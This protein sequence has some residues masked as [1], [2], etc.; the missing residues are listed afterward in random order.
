[1]ASHYAPSAAVEIVDAV[2][3]ADRAREHADADR[4]VG[5]LAPSSALGDLPDGLV[6]LDPPHDTADYARVL[7]ARLRA[8]DELDLDVLLVVLPPETDGLGAAIADRV[9]RAGR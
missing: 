4:R 7:Y 6:V 2:A 1:L 5:V 3:V 8:A 9:R